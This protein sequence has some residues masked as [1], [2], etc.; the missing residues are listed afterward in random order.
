MNTKKLEHLQQVKTIQ[1][2]EIK[3]KKYVKGG[4]RAICLDGVLY[5]GWM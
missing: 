4:R 1:V 5:G 3:K 2:I